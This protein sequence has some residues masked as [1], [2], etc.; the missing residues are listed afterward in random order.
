MSISIAL[1]AKQQSANCRPRFHR[2]DRHISSRSV[3]DS[4]SLWSRQGQ[5]IHSCTG[6]RT[7]ACCAPLQWQLMNDSHRTRQSKRSFSRSRWPYSAQWHP[8]TSLTADFA[9]QSDQSS[10]VAYPQDKCRDPATQG[11]WCHTRIVLLPSIGIE[12]MLRRRK[13]GLCSLRV[14]G[15]ELSREAH[16]L[17]T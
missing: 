10:R 15:T 3:L 11:H 5:A 8:S 16:P 17:L 7:R 9:Q 12:W 14:G 6:P 4:F 1:L 2:Y 13:P